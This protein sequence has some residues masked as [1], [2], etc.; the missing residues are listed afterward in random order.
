[1][2]LLHNT[3]HGELAPTNLLEK[4]DLELDYS[5]YRKDWQ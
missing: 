1:M 5:M 4:E 3:F 2:F